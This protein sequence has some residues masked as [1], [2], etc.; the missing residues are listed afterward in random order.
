MSSP[1]KEAVGAE[2]GE[3]SEPW[4]VCARCEDKYCESENTDKSCLWYSRTHKGKFIVNH[5]SE[6]WYGWK[7]WNG[8]RNSTYCR[9]KFG[10]E[11]GFVWTRCGCDHNRDECERECRHKPEDASLS[12]DDYE[13]SF[14]SYE[15]SSS[16]HDNKGDNQATLVAA[17][18]LREV[19]GYYDEDDDDDD[20][21]DSS[22]DE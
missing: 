5:D 9:K 20:D 3:M 8:P 2:A 19:G 7:E 6:F 12:D 14:H 13:I 11:G 1:S 18:L 4:I 15:S 16:D 10:I 22:D 17:R 21:D